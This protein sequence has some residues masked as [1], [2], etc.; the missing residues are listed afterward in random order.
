MG[1]RS[2]EQPTRQVRK[3]KRQCRCKDSRTGHAAGDEWSPLHRSGNH[4]VASLRWCF[5]VLAAELGRLGAVLNCLLRTQPPSP[6]VPDC[7]LCS[8][9][10]ELPPPKSFSRR[11][12]P[13]APPPT[14]LLS[15][16]S[17]PPIHIPAHGAYET[18]TC[19]KRT[20]VHL[21]TRLLSI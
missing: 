21:A 15:A 20:T 11:A 13:R 7:L 8:L 9:A 12:P 1:K 10:N 2:Q 3:T 4:L 19:Q 5:A 6:S 16:S 14:L 18:V 17:N